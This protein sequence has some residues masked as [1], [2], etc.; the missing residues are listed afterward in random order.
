MRSPIITVILLFGLVVTPKYA[1]TDEGS[2]E[3][4][5]THN[6]PIFNRGILGV[7]GGYVGGS[8]DWANDKRGGCWTGV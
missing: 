4:A 3:F 6:A 1:F 8:I 2:F 7:F 5:D